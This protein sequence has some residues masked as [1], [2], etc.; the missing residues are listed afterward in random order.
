MT[1]LAITG[2]QDPIHICYENHAQGSKN[3]CLPVLA[4]ALL[5]P[6]TVLDHV[7]DIEDVWALLALF[8][9]TGVH[10]EMKNGQFTARDE[11]DSAVIPGELFSRTRAGFF[12]IAARIYRLGTIRLGRLEEAGCR[13][14]ARGFGPTLEVFRRFG[15]R[16]ETNQNGLMFTVPAGPRCACVDLDDL[17]LCRTG[18]A[19]V[20][21]AQARGTSVL[22]NPGRAPELMD[23]VALL[24]G[25]GV[26]IAIEKDAW[27]VQGCRDFTPPPPFRVQEDRIVIGTYAVL[28]LATG[29]TFRIE[30]ARM[31]GLEALRIHLAA[32]GCS[33]DPA[34]DG[35][36]VIQAPEGLGP[37]E[38]SIGDYPA[39][40]T[41]LQPIL[42]LLACRAS[43][44]SR[45]VDPIFPGRTAHLQELARMGQAFTPSGKGWTVEGGRPFRGAHVRGHDLRCAAALVVAACLAQGETVIE[46]WNHLCRGYAK[47]L[48]LVSRHRQVRMVEPAGRGTAPI[49]LS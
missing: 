34:P 35:S 21:A 1:L 20:L 28:A 40:P 46:D 30:P 37:R 36:V 23:L 15:I 5:A 47:L 39:L 2:R 41:D 43:G 9:K 48:S 38:V 17:G 11:G 26:E 12:V 29:G 49:R 3:A 31:A 10:A 16:V 32:S 27:T 7:P 42:T 44:P 19:L 8:R 4:A 33:L 24:R 13:I 18:V 25:M 22:N 14:G 6:G 45:V